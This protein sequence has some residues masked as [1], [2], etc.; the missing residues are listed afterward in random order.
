[1]SSAKKGHLASSMLKPLNLPSL[2]TG[3][4]QVLSSITNALVGYFEIPKLLDQVVSTSMATLHAEVSSIFLVERDKNPP[5][6]IMRAGSGF[7]KALVGHAKYEIGEGF[8]GYIVKHKRGFNIR[9]RKE[10]ETLAIDGQQI[11]QGKHDSKQ[12]PSKKSEFR[13]CIALPLLIK[14]ECLGAIKVE[15]KRPK[16]GS[17]FTDDEYSYFEIIANVVA[18]AIEN[19]KLHQQT[20]NQLKAIAGKAAHRIHNHAANYDGIEMSLADEFGKTVPDKSQLNGVVHRLQET[21]RS[22]KRMTEEFKNYGKP[23]KLE[24]ALTDINEVITDEVWLAKPPDT[25]QIS[26]QL[27]ERLPKVMIDGPRFAEAIKELLRNSIKAIGSKVGGRGKI[28]VA[29]RIAGEPKK[30]KKDQLSGAQ[31]FSISIIDDGPGFQPGFP[32]F[33]PFHSTDPGS[34][35]LGLA[36]VRELIEAHDGRVSLHRG[37][38]AHIEID[39]PILGHAEKG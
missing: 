39:M 21:T 9:S 23:I 12:W 29:S 17:F 11:W 38:G 20:E 25:I 31:R 5:V 2:E 3:S 1:M 34:T 19:A 33:E 28:V 13:N 8:T 36:T 24:L 4:R 10:L 16:F 26:T 22:L 35:G 15:N 18:L 37:G 27:D 6:V 14:G 30:R 7:A 32:V